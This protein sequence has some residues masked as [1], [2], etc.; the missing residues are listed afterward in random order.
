M[1]KIIGDALVALFGAPVAHE[2]DAE[3]AVRCALHM[4]HTLIDLRERLAVHQDKLAV[5][6]CQR[7]RR[8]HR[9][10]PHWSELRRVCPVVLSNSDHTA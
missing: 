6:E 10:I 2:D 4:Q 7:L 3:R 8:G 1:D 5:Q 9:D